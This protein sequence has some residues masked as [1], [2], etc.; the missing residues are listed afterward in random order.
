MSM[1]RSDFSIQF[2]PE[3]LGHLDAIPRQ[4]HSLLRAVIHE[5]L[6]LTPLARYT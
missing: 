2:A 4:H 6:R 1:G 3:V 5:Q